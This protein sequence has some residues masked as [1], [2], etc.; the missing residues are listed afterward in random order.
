MKKQLALIS[1][2]ALLLMSGCSGTESLAPGNSS[3][4]D[5]AETTA[6]TES[7]E[8]PAAS[9]EPL[10]RESSL[11]FDKA[12]NADAEKNYLTAASAGKPRSAEELG[13]VRATPADEDGK[14]EYRLE[15][16]QANA[17]VNARSKDDISVII[18]P[19]Y[20]YNIP[21]PSLEAVPAENYVF[22]INGS[23]VV[24]DSLCVGATSSDLHE[25]N[26]WCYAAVSMDIL[27][28]ASADGIVA[29]GRLTSLE[30]ISDA[31]TALDVCLLG[32]SA[33]DEKGGNA[34]ETYKAL[35]SIKDKLLAD[36]IVGVNLI[37]LD[38]DDKPEILVARSV[39]VEGASDWCSFSD[40]DIYCVNDSVPEYVDTLYNNDTGLMGSHGN[41]IGLK[42]LENG[43]KAWFTMSRVNRFDESSK[44]PA[45]Y[46]FTLKDGK[47]EFTELFSSSGDEYAEDGEAVHYFMNGEE[48]QFEVS[49]DY[50]PYYDPNDEYWKDAKPDYPYYSYGEYTASFGKWEIYGWLR[51][52]Y[53][54][55]I[56]QTFVLYSDQFCA[57]GDGQKCEKLPVTE[58]M[59]EY[60]LA[61][62]TDAYYFG[63]YDPTIQNYGYRFLGDYAKPVIYLYPEETTDVTVK[64][65]PDGGL[66][67]TYPDYRD[68]WNVTA[69]PDGTL[70]DNADGRE[71]YCLYWEGAGAA[72]WDMS[73]GEVVRGSD[74]AEF[75]EEKLAEIG[76]TPRE[77]N[78]FI[79]Y[80]LPRMQQN[81]YNYITFHTEDYSAAVPMEVTPQP[82][83][84]LRVFMVYASVP[85]YF[86]TQPQHFNGFV[87]NGFTLVEWGGGEA[88]VQ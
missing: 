21:L 17:F 24:C 36:D 44:N 39:N 63:E 33:F 84:V 72:E 15:N 25:T 23:K 83:S 57:V 87:R 37:D 73:S 26:G 80:W 9:V 53:C 41:V 14:Y 20:M 31:E 69:Y 61:N 56:E 42:Q 10:F 6:P 4:E 59:I 13:L 2:I 54:A 85:E 38:F 18:D 50:D 75:L 51:N 66:T 52:D 43:E 70:V 55:D 71:Y 16:V 27:Y 81:E 78:E 47:L 1:A 77:R 12:D 58:R 7:S 30:K 8:E 34:A 79:I 67:C 76:L 29:T 5:S 82:D 64:V 40:V 35:L 11:F 32:D 49:Y 60:K 74:T 45:D 19:A 88:A 68:G 22:D 46:L 3:L 86:E 28:T 48:I 65:S 62:L